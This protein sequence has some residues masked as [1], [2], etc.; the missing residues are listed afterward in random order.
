MSRLFIKAITKN[1]PAHGCRSIF[2]THYWK[3]IYVFE[4]DV[5]RNVAFF[6]L[7]GV[8]ILRRNRRGRRL[9]GNCSRKKN[10]LR[11]FSC[12]WYSNKNSIQQRDDGVVHIPIA[13]HCKFMAASGNEL[14][15]VAASACGWD[16]RHT[17]S[18]LC[19]PGRLVQPLIICKERIC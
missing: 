9:L 11:N 2:T 4:D 12:I 16:G 6:P 1:I 3:C 7:F 18:S 14:R 8:L 17:R 13:T 19:Q 15:P 5:C 10:F